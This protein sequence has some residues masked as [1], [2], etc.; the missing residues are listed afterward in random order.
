MIGRKGTISGSPLQ[1]S[2]LVSATSSKPRPHSQRKDP[3]LPHTGL[4]F[5]ASKTL[6]ME[7]GISAASRSPSKTGRQLWVKRWSHN[8]RGLRLAL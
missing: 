4:V 2:S 3:L 5:R 8:P 7:G 6:K 1:P